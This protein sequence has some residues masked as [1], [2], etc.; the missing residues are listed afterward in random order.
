MA[1][2]QAERG[3]DRDAVFSGLEAVIGVCCRG[4]ALDI[5][6][7]AITGFEEVPK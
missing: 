6:N 4:T 5:F 7:D 2:R 3:Q 1:A